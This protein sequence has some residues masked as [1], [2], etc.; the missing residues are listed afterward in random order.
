MTKR[1]RPQKRRKPDSLLEPDMRAIEAQCHAAL[2][3]LDRLALRMDTKWGVDRLVE[4]VD[5]ETASKYGSAMGRLN[6]ALRALDAEQCVHMAKVCMRGLK[7]MDEIAEARNEKP[8]ELI[9]EFDFGGTKIGIMQDATD[10]KPIAEKRPDLT[11]FSLREVGVALLA[12]KSN[13]IV[14][15]IKARFPGAEMQPHKPKL[16]SE[17]WRNGGDPLPNLEDT[18]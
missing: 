15:E 6:E 3:P 18:W 8:S 2:A 14:G 7:K 17:F 5:P 13:S 10:W 16:K 11:L 12:A 4:L 1:T 9:A